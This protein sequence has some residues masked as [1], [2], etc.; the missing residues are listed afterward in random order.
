[1]NENNEIEINLAEMCK[2][3][4][5]KWLIVLVA[6]LVGAGVT[7]GISK[8]KNKTVYSAEA[9][10]YISI[11]KTSDKVLIRDNVNELVLDYMELIGTDIVLEKVSKETNIEL[12]EI[13][14]SVLVSQ[15][16]GKRFILI[17]VKNQ[18]KSKSE[19]II[20]SVLNVTDHTITNTLGKD[21]PIIVENR[22]EPKKE[23]TMD[24][25]KNSL[26][27]AALG[28]VFALGILFIKFILISKRKSQ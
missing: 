19:A 12:S 25:K 16:A 5:S 4:L 7:A 15:I 23:N 27:G 2:Y 22:S 21:K 17:N 14:K 11:P 8:I 3:F 26:V 20:K 6:I 13:R 28:I 18:S 9:K 10:L 24:I 1:M